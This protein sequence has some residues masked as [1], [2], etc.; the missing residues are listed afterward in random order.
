MK[1]DFSA[2]VAGIVLTYAAVPAMAETSALT[3]A[4]LNH[5]ASVSQAVGSGTNL[6]NSSISQV[7]SANSATVSHSRASKMSYASSAITQNSGTLNVTSVTQQS[8]AR[9]SA[10][11]LSA[12]GGNNSQANM[13]QIGVAGGYVLVYQ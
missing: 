6:N 3:H 13:T 7:G 11:V 4:G 2:I 5:T 1:P 8:S 9:V 10:T 12:W